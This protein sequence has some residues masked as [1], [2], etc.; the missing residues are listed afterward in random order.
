MFKETSFEE[1]N[2]DEPHAAP[3]SNTAPSVLPHVAGPCLYTLRYHKPGEDGFC[4]VAN[5]EGVGEGEGIPWVDSRTINGDSW[6]SN[7]CHCTRCECMRVM[8]AL[9][10]LE[11][12]AGRPP[13]LV[14]LDLDNFGFNQFKST[15]PVLKRSHRGRLGCTSSMR[16]PRTDAA[17]GEREGGSSDDGEDCYSSEVDMFENMFVWA[18]FG[19][20]F[21]RYHGTWPSEE[22]VTQPPEPRQGRVRCARLRQPS[23]LAVT[24][25]AMSTVTLDPLLGS[26]SRPTVWQRL[27]AAGRVHF[28]ACGGQGQ[29]ADGVI[30]SVIN[31]FI[32]RDI[33]LITCDAQLIRRIIRPRQDGDGHIS[34]GRLH[35]INV[36]DVGKRLVPV[37]RALSDRIRQ[38]VVHEKGK[39]R[40]RRV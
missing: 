1:G 15:P 9:S 13:V 34:T 25:T 30:V 27:V 18:F 31:T 5:G 21:A 16:R 37:W 35:A 7:V 17:C 33:V 3:V 22:V 26:V 24:S 14:L 40:A 19:S 12:P 32:Q 38:L 2:I 39:N 10:R 29:G 36:G 6:V 4:S 8:V 11:A 20:C 28:T 23:A